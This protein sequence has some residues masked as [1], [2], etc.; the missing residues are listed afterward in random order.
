LVERDVSGLKARI[1]PVGPDGG[2]RSH[3]RERAPHGIAAVR[4]AA[5]PV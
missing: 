3:Q 4:D 2:L 5:R 1:W